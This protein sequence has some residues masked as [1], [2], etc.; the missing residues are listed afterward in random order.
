MQIRESQ[1]LDAEEMYEIFLQFIVYLGRTVK[2]WC[3]DLEQQ[4]LLPPPAF[5]TFK[6]RLEQWC[7]EGSF[8]SHPIGSLAKKVLQQVGD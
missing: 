2:K 7:T 6:K 5:E 1:V 3:H 8:Y 4:K